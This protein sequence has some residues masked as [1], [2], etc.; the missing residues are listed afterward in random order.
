M[1][2][3]STKL[4]S[5]LSRQVRGHLGK[6]GTEIKKLTIGWIYACCLIVPPPPTHEVVK[7]FPNP[8]YFKINAGKKTRDHFL[9]IVTKLTIRLSTLSLYVRGLGDSGPE[10]T[11]FTVV[12]EQTSY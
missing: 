4:L 1:C 11:S 2:E 5:T 12:V 10:I 3:H 6:L 7:H 8:S 9:N